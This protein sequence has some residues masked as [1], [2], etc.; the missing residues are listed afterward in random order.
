MV[1]HDMSLTGKFSRSLTMQDGELIEAEL[2]PAFDKTMM[3][4]RK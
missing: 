2:E 4:R 3:R 1:T